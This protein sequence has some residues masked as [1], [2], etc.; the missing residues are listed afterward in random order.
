MSA[1]L[2]TLE[3]GHTMTNK[4]GGVL[5]SDTFQVPNHRLLTPVGITA[6]D[7]F[8]EHLARITGKDIPLKH[9][10]E[11]GRLVDS[12][13]DGH[14][15]LSGKK[16]IIYGEEDLV[17]GLSG[18]LAEIG[19]IPV[20]CASGGR[21]GMLAK[22]IGEATGDILTE[23]PAV[24]EGMDFF[25]ISERAESLQP[26]ILIGH[27]KGAPLAKKLNIPL[28][29]V[30]FPIHDRMGGQR[31]LHL[32]YRGAQ[33]LFDRIINSII[34]KKQADSPVGYSYM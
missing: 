26:D 27:S 22:K 2:A 30:G 11:R 29:R 10:Q 20:L 14:K 25:E 31:I 1:N 7:T 33:N 32:G 5:L 15:Y 3:F 34:A 8:M 13:I 24:C 18:F 17:A 21:S 28:I 23:P 9:R 4:S 19:I 16:A 6:T 12:Y